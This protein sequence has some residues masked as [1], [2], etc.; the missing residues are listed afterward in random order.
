MLV[1][2][3]HVG[4]ILTFIYPEEERNTGVTLKILGNSAKS[5]I[6][7]RKNLPLIIAVLTLVQSAISF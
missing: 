5:L 3:D 2:G 6:N 1:P 4:A 7:I